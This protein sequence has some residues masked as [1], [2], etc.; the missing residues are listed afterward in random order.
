MIRIAAPAFNLV[1]AAG[2]RVSRLVGRDE[3]VYPLR[4]PGQAFELDRLAR[5]SRERLDAQRAE[6][7]RIESGQA[8]EQVGAQLASDRPAPEPG[9]APRSEAGA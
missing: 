9:S 5:E 3:P 6:R 1:L 4:P 2:D 7:E 8:D